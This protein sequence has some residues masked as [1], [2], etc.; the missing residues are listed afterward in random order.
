L[1]LHAIPYDVEKTCQAIAAL[2]LPRDYIA[3]WQQAF[4]TGYLPSRYDS[5]KVAV[6]RTYGYR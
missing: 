3:D 5:S 4:R 2:P 1:T 6:L